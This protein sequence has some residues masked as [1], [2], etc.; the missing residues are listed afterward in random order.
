MIPYL[1]VAYIC[2]NTPKKPCFAAPEYDSFACNSGEKVNNYLDPEFGYNFCLQNGMC[3]S[4]SCKQY[5]NMFVSVDING[6]HR[7]G[8]ILGRDVFRFGIGMKSTR[9]NRMIRVNPGQS[10]IYDSNMQDL[11]NPN[12]Y[13][14]G[15]SN[16]Q[17]Y[18]WW[19]GVSG[20]QHG[21]CAGGHN[22]AGVIAK[23]GWKI[24]DDYPLKKMAKKMIIK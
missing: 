11:K 10:N 8:S 1:K 16:L 24:P 17:C 2:N 9:L 21:G 6:P 7:G 14:W 12:G 4:V 5:S 15:Y 22:C 18:S 19:T 20:A 23:N 13:K 3:M